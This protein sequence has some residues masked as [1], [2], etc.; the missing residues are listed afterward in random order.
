M[1]HQVLPEKEPSAS[2]SAAAAEPETVE[3][4][5][6]DLFSESHADKKG[7]FQDTTA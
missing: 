2:S 6:P 3:L 7:A 4:E 5:H 1:L